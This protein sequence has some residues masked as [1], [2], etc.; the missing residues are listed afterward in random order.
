MPTSEQAARFDRVRRRCA[1]CTPYQAAA[2]PRRHERH[3]RG[4][5]ARRQGSEHGDDQENERADNRFGE[6]VG[7]QLPYGGSRHR[8]AGNEPRREP[9]AVIAGDRQHGEEQ[10]DLQQQ[11]AAVGG[12]EQ[13]RPTAGELEGVDDA[14]REH[15][16]DAHDA[17]GQ[18]RSVAVRTTASVDRS[19]CPSPRPARS[20]TARARRPPRGG[21]D[22]MQY[23]GGLHDDTFDAVA[24]RGMPGEG[25][26]HDVGRRQSQ[27]R[28][29]PQCPRRRAETGRMERRREQHDEREPRQPHMA[30]IG[31][32]Q[33]R[34]DEIVR[35]QVGQRALAH[36]RRLHQQRGAGGDH[37]A[38]D[39][40]VR[41]QADVSLATNTLG[42][43]PTV[44]LQDG[45]AR[46]VQ[47]FADHYNQIEASLSV[48]A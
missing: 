7:A 5:A 37:G 20:P 14:G 32:E 8:A 23:V 25:E 31:I 18:N 29:S 19:P 45:L 30:E 1:P 11:K 16:A 44:A 47:W 13:R 24:G 48:N 40:S 21:G 6:C 22:E 12:A 34:R 41:R 42:F 2:L 46:T 28:A 9:N 15:G 38:W 17:E 3:A 10:R 36:A 27:R 35:P 4:L 26:R 39:H 43:Q 33:H